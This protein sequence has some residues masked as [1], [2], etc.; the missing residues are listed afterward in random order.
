[1]HTNP[2]VFLRLIPDRCLRKVPFSPTFH[3]EKINFHL[4]GL[5]IRKE[6]WLYPGIADMARKS[7]LGRYVHM[8]RK[9]RGVD[10]LLD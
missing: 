8:A 6:V 3:F 7:I 2:G 5:K 1:M 4:Q 10:P 9:I